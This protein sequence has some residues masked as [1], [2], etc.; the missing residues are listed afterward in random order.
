MPTSKPKA[1]AS[2][3]TSGKTAEHLQWNTVQRKVADLVPYDLNPRGISDKERRDLQTSINKFGLV[4]IPAIDA[5]NKILAGHQR[6]A[7][8]MLLGKGNE[9]IDVRMPNR[10]LTE[11]EFKEYNIRSNRHAGVFDMEMLQRH[12]KYED[13]MEWGFMATELPKGMGFDTTMLG[14]GKS[15]NR[16]QKIGYMYRIE[17]DSVDQNDKWN[18]FVKQLFQKYPDAGSI[19]KRILLFIKNKGV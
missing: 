16:G 14:E 9:T 3:N 15:V 6:L 19:S 17:F 12:F 18:T 2:S 1:N 7:I 13:L 10:K 11:S 4:E 8:L 5:D